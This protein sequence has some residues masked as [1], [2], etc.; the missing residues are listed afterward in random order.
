MQWPW[1]CEGY[2]A[3]KSDDSSLLHICILFILV[4]VDDTVS[5]CDDTGPGF[6][7]SKFKTFHVGTN[8]SDYCVSF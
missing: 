4:Y 8:N 6:T 2:T 7:V 5:L 3:V 1:L